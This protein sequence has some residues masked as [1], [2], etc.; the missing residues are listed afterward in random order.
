VPAL[1]PR[2]SQKELS[3]RLEITESRVSRSLNNPAAHHLRLLWSVADDLDQ[4]LRLN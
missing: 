2:P 4:V 3:H 1:L